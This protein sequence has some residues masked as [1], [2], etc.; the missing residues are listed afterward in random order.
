MINLIV[1]VGPKGAIG[2]KG[3]LPWGTIK[4][5]MAHF[6]EVTMGSTLVMGRKTYESIGK[7]LEG[8]LTFVVSRTLEPDAIE[9][10]KIFRSVKEALDASP[11][12]ETFLA[13]GV[14]IYKEGLEYIDTMY[15]TRVGLED[16]EA[17]TYL[18][19]DMLFGNPND[20]VLEN[21]QYTKDSNTGASL[22]FL[23]FLKK[24]SWGL[25]DVGG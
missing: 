25:Y 3:K 4:K 23:T 9:G 22:M 19:T 20:W 16:C 21:S 7:P 2:N 17:D 11:T 24:S 8:R 6:K 12:E 13:G 14:E 18:P 10:V 1:A 5:D 15:I